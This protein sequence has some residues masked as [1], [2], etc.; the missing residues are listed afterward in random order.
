MKAVLL[1]SYGSPDN[2]YIGEASSPIPTSLQV[3]VKIHATALN[4]AD[5]MQRQGKYPPPKGESDIL[6]LEMAGEVVEVGDK[7][8]KWNVGDKVC[9]LLGSGGYAQ[10]VVIHE[11]MALPI[12]KGFSYEMAAAIPE[13][14]LTAFQAL[15]W[16][17]NLQAGE[18]VLLHA[19]ASGVGTAAIQLC[20]AIGVDHIFVTASRPKHSSC[21][22]LGADVAIDY[23]TQN[24]EE[25]VNAATDG[26][27]VNL[28][29]DF[30]AAPYFQKNLNVLAMDGRLVMLSLMGGYKAKEV[31]LIPILRKRL[32][33]QGSTLRARSLAYKINL[34]RDLYDF[35]WSKF[36]NGILKPIIDSTFDWSEVGEAHRYMEA[37]K[38]IG[39][40]I[41][42]IN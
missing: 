5:T 27:G 1:K 6:G 16:I 41:L 24:F 30:L 8:T 38:N 3:L 22:K 19:G 2:L 35:A 23:K 20:K 39:K 9:G 7:V 10:Y 18:K 31:N 32:S 15:V 14:F 25:V 13:V 21:L 11:D 33:I 17:G 42:T 26:K 29:L 34:T 28:V 40:I 36:E 4:R 37:N 12:P